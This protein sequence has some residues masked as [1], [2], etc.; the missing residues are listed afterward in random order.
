M[1]SFSAKYLARR[2]HHVW[3]SADPGHL[4]LKKCEE[5]GIRTVPIP[6]A[7][8]SRVF[9]V[10]GMLRDV[11]RKHAIDVVHSNANYD[12]TCAA[13]AAAFQS[14]RHVA[15]VHSAHSI[16]HNIT[17]WMRNRWGVDQFI[18]DADAVKT[19]LM[20]DDGSLD[21][22]SRWFRSAW[23]A[24]SQR[25]RR[26]TRRNAGGTGDDGRYHCYRQC[27][28]AGAV[29]RASM[30]SGGGRNGVAGTDGRGLPDRWRRR[31]A[32]DASRTGPLTRHRAAGAVPWV[33]R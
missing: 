21:H 27:R 23:K 24:A 5:S 4:L 17:H 8:M 16:Q 1:S 13:L 19:V 33:P 2:G 25:R 18:A 28:E 12:R 10:S 14:V 7:G 20:E 11:L 9:A 3:V 15:G 32:G 31:T 30:P 6:Y 22:V 26:G 29:Q